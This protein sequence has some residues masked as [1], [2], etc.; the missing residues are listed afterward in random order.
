MRAL[1]VR[2]LDVETAELFEPVVSAV[3]EHATGV[4]ILRL[5]VLALPA[6][7]PSSYYGSEEAA[8]ERLI[9]A[10]AETAGIE[11]TAGVADSLFA[12]FLEA[13]RGVI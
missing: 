7:G 4:E 11:C 3:E 2:C 12:A 10:V 8:S 6:R 13:R 9:D 1:V 5:G